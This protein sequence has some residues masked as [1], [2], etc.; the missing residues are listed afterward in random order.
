VQAG[1]APE[2]RLLYTEHELREVRKLQGIGLA[3]RHELD[4]GKTP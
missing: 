3:E 1:R 2:P 4:A